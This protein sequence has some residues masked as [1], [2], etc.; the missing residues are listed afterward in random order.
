MKS[1]K[2]KRKKGEREREREA[3]EKGKVVKRGLDEARRG[4]ACYFYA[5]SHRGGFAVIAF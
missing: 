2:E 4:T 3:K 5:D 1:G